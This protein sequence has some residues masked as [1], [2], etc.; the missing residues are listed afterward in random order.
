M[1]VRT[2]SYIFQNTYNIFRTIFHKLP[3]NNIFFVELRRMNMPALITHQSEAPKKISIDEDTD[4]KSREIA[5][6]P[7]FFL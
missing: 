7:I 2:R 6:S 4:S 5:W 1:K 3:S